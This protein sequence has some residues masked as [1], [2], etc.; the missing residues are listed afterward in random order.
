[1]VAYT[2][3]A[4]LARMN[5]KLMRAAPERHMR[6][7]SHPLEMSTPTKTLPLHVRPPPIVPMREAIAY[8]PGPSVMLLSVEV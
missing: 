7:M 3:V 1:M 8:R 2:F 5:P 6:V 4:R